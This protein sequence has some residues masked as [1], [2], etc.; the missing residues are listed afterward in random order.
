MATISIDYD[1]TGDVEL[2]LQEQDDENSAKYN[3]GPLGVKV[4]E[5]HLRVS[6]LKLISS[7]HYFQAMLEDSE[8]QEGKELKQNGFL[9]IELL[10]PEDDPTAMM[11]ILGILYGKEI[12]MP[13]E[14]GLEM[15][16]R[17]T[18]L[19][20][21]YHWHALVTSHAI[22]WYDGLL[23]SLGLPDAFDETLLTWLWIAWVFGIRR[24]FKAL[25]QVAMQDARKS[26][27]LTD[28]AIRLPIRALSKW[29]LLL[30]NLTIGHRHRGL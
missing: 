13:N 30:P 28:E 22:S 26:I 20:D 6:S 3:L 9:E 8:F 21:K 10:D 23:D 24:R 12:R 7:S 19:V 29:P 5:V 25:S 27:D 1:S 14:V 11:I 4:K 18:V 17:V 2:I 16:N 15:L